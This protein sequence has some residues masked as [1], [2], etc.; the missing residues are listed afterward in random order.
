MTEYAGTGA[1]L[2]LALRLDR[3]RASAWILG[4]VVFTV[5]S[6]SANNDLYGEP[7][8]RAQLAES[9]E[10]N[11]ALLALG[12]RAFDLSTV[13]GI[14]AYQLIAF[15]G[16]L[17]GLMSVL[18]TVRHTRVEE[19]SGR[20]EL[21]GSAVV[22]RRAWLASAL[23]LTVGVNVVI[24]V[25]TAMGLVATGL[26]V[27]GSVAYAAGCAGI[28]VVFAFVAGLT[29]QLTDSS[30]SATGLAAAVL[31][32]SYLLR[33]TG[34]AASGS[35]GG[36]LSVLTWFSP[37]GWAE[38]ARPYAGEDWWV[39]LLFVALA[40]ALAGGIGVLVGR[41]D[42][43]SGVLRPTLGPARA[44]AA[45]GGPLA[46]AWRLQRGSLLGW[47]VGFLVVGVSF[48]A[49]A[50]G[51]V[52]IAEDNENIDELL[53]DLGGSG[54]IVDVFLST[55]MSLTSIIVGAYAV[56][57]ALRL[58]SEESGRRADTLLTNA[59]ERLRW[60]GSHL[61]VAALGSVLMLLLA[62]LGAGVA[63][64]LN[65]G[66]LGGELP[67]V[68]GAALAQVPAVWTLVGVCALLFGLAPRFAAVSWGV[69]LAA[70]VIGQF[71]DLLRLNQT[72]LNLSPFT[73]VPDLP[74]AAFEATPLLGL[75]VLAALLTA[76][77]LGGFR[78]RDIA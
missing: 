50:E 67:R 8:E 1:L 57:S 49:L 63:H 45:L 69:L 25:L 35:D 40:A 72:V 19:E 77:G 34:D 7:S 6:A 29:A 36:A 24:A 54:D 9:L 74:G 75:A 59:V 64:G 15:M 73:H 30:R 21:A 11:P 58:S 76:V 68:L 66:D 26:P 62:G 27:A 3:V 43:G 71:G 47:G 46:L 2:R 65:T 23:L 16:T 17:I 39:L 41:R 56:Q 32:L 5:S 14:N 78:R 31:G 18:L 38:M 20:A 55:T 44:S 13:G 42:V 51:T 52:S 33:A 12:G 48:G 22:G 61:S 60:V 53:R 70:L 28:G 37:I 10:S 4:M